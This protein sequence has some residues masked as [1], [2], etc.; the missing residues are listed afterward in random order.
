MKFALRASLALPMVAWVLTACGR[1]EKQ[2]STSGGTLVVYNA[3]SLARPLRTALDTF[4][5]HNGVTIQQENAGSL[6][7][8]RKLTELHKIPDIIGLADYEVFPQLLMPQ[9]VT[10]YA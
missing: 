5:A 7:T 1:A 8:A 10:W 3:G 4:A 2:P 9:Y 6:E